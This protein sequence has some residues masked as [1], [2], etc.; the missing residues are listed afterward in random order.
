MTD[1]VVHSDGIQIDEL[2]VRFPTPGGEP[3]TAVDRVSQRI[4]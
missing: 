2:S 3:V 4:P 1:R